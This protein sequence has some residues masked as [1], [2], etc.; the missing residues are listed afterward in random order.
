MPSFKEHSLFAILFILPFFPNPYSIAL[1]LIGAA[2]VDFDHNIKKENIYKILIIGLLATLVLYILSLPY[3]IGLIIVLIGLIF[4]FSNH[5]GFTHSLLGTVLLTLLLTVLIALSFILLN[6][7]LLG[8]LLTLPLATATNLPISIVGEMNIASSISIV[9]ILIILGVL[10]INKRLKIPFIILLLLGMVLIP[11]TVW[12]DSNPIIYP[13]L[14]NFFSEL[15]NLNLLESVIIQTIPETMPQAILPTMLTMPPVISILPQLLF[16]FFIMMI[17]LFLGFV[18][19]LAIDSL[20]PQGI[21]LL[22]PISSKKIKK[23]FGLSIIVLWIIFSIIS[24]YLKVF[25]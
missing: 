15:I 14:N 25:S 4:Y 12:I 2:L 1:A 17:S 16:S 11:Y 3:I 24:V 22:R 23:V 10:S 5:R 19:H 8:I 18:S 21:E 13:F 7:I 20:T 6:S 9:T